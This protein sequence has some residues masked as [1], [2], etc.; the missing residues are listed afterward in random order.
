[1]RDARLEN[2]DIE[3]ANQKHVSRDRLQ[4]EPLSDTTHSTHVQTCF[5]IEI[6]NQKHVSRDR[7]QI[8]PLSDTTHSTHVQTCFRTEE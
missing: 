2:E 5:R 3:I 6:A 1:M 7:L 4:I 8:E